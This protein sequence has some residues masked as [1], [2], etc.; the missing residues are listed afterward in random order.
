MKT[1]WHVRS[2]HRGTSTGW[3]G[4]GL[5]LAGFLPF[6]AQG[7]EPGGKESQQ[8]ASGAQHG[9]APTTEGVKSDA[10]KAKNVPFK[11]GFPEDYP[12]RPSNTLQLDWYAST[13]NMIDIW[14]PEGVG[15][16]ERGSLLMILHEEA[17]FRFERQAKGS[18][19]HEFEKP[20]LLRLVA[21]TRPIEDGIEME[22]AI[23]NL[24]AEGWT[25]VSAGV[26]VQFHAAPDFLDPERRRTFYL[27]D[28]RLRPL[29]G[30]TFSD[31]YEINRF[32]RTSKDP[33]DPAYPA[34]DVGFIA[35]EAA[36][37]KHTAALWWEGSKVVG[38]NAHPATACI[39]ADPQFG[40]I[41]AGATATCK[42][43]LYLMPGTA[44]QARKRF[45]RERGT[46]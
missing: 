28:G 38:G 35:V 34:A 1:S 16:A 30:P 29:S 15:C 2:S 13:R 14:L 32:F 25:D 33:A 22:L 10:P 26:C 5:L 45:E 8:D 4:L 3:Y 31:P 21:V 6:M 37:G 7:A 42:G 20:G 46:L 24:S 17:D 40:D 36:D 11:P 27:V 41:K 18:W 12:I 9:E 43:R 23:T 39:H 44:D 19:R